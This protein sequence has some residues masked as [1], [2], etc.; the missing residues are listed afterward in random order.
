MAK[1]AR[2]A[3]QDGRVGDKE[4]KYE[5]RRQR[6][7]FPSFLPLRLFT[8]IPRRCP[9]IL[10]LSFPSPFSLALLWRFTFFRLFFLEGNIKNYE[11]DLICLPS[12]YSMFSPFCAW[13]VFYSHF[14]RQTRKGLVIR[15]SPGKLG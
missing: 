4:K 5:R 6:A 9:L 11:N 15:V 7:S 14:E 10:L 13:E 3:G 2:G 1:A 8:Q 12:A